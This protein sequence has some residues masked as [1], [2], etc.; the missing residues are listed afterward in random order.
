MERRPRMADRHGARVAWI[1]IAPVKG[2]ALESLPAALLG[3]D[4]VA[5]DRAFHLVDPLG[6]LVN[7]KHLSRLMLVRPEV[8]DGQLVLRFPD[9]TAVGGALELGE[10]VTTG[11]YGRPVGG[12]LVRGPWSRALSE[13]ARSQV[14]LVRVERPGDGLD[15][16]PHAAAT[17]LGTGSLDA[18]AAAGG[19]DRRP[20]PRRFRMLLGVDGVAP[21]AEDGWLGRHVRVGSAVL[22][23]R[24]NVGRCVVTT[25]H[26]DTAAHDLDT[27]KLLARYRAGVRTTEALPFGVWAEVV[28]P[29]PVAV[30]DPV[31]VD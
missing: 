2:L 8:G 6:R 21:H 18:F 20:D 1:T 30:G 15:R 11:F 7:G 25:Y 9:G 24:G 22:V 19:L 13:Y 27:L 17:L 3:R 29:G 5:G 14:R 31:A 16:G 4:G 10:P 12:R 28:E 26:P 23:P